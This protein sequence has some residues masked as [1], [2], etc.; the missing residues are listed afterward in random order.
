MVLSSIVLSIVLAHTFQ[1]QAVITAGDVHQNDKPKSPLIEKWEPP[2]HVEIAQG[3][4]KRN[5][6]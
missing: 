4:K 5:P 3:R 1:T 6:G 2:S